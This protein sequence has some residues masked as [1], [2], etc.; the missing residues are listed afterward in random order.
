MANSIGLHPENIPQEL[1]DRRQWVVRKNETVRGRRTKVPYQ[2]DGT[3]ALVND[4]TTW[5]IFA[6]ALACYQTGE[7]DGTGYVFAADDPYCGID[8]DGCRNPATGDLDSF[9][10][11][12]TERFPTYT[13]ISPSGTGVKLI[14]KGKLP[15]DPQR[16][17]A[18]TRDSAIPGDG[19]GEKRPGIEAYQERRWFAMTGIPLTGAP[20]DVREVDQT[21]L[22]DW[23]HQTFDR[24]ASAPKVNGQ[25]S[26]D[27]NALIG[28]ARQYL[29]TM[30]PAISGQRG[31]DTT[32]RVA[33]VL[34]CRFGLTEDEA[35]VAVAEWNARCE[36]P[37][38]EA[39]LRHKLQDAAQEP[40]TLD[41]VATNFDRQDD[42]FN[43]ESS[44]LIPFSTIPPREVTWLWKNRIPCGRISVLGG[45]QGLGKS[46]LTIDFAGRIS[47]GTAWPDGSPCESG[48]V[49]FISGEDD[50]RDTIRP[51]LDA[52]GADLSRIWTFSTERRLGTK[53]KR[54]QTVFTLADVELLERAL[55]QTPD[56][57]LIVIDPIGAYVG[58]KVNTSADNEVRAVLGPIA[59]LAEASGSAVL[60][61]AHHRKSFGNTADD[62]IMGS[63]AFTALA[64]SVWHVFPDPSDESRRMLVAGKN[65][66]APR[67]DGFAFA[68]SG[69]PVRVQWDSKP[70]TMSA[71]ECLRAQPRVGTGNPAGE[72]RS[73][74]LSEA[75]D[76]LEAV[77]AEG[78]RPASEIKKLAREDGIAARTLDR[79][80]TALKI[81]AQL[82][83]FKGR[84]VWS[85][86]DAD[87][88]RQETSE[89]ADTNTLAHSDEPGALCP[90]IDE[91]FPP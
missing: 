65:N 15:V 60:I 13:E 24:P 7:W 29:A 12:I 4:S 85:L 17:G 8:A 3:K 30:P 6:D 51:R 18:K 47:S 73:S 26:G 37:W 9:A 66:L 46:Y 41:L 22:D 35:L 56:C 86:P 87:R 21:D 78:P 39:E 75:V 55:S 72:S 5:T 59:Q 57:K 43:E 84:W 67:Q 81:V 74:A 63:R 10:R 71:D 28:R 90:W 23:F 82:E 48:S 62:M 33:C 89:C 77:L 45:P 14:L 19:Y 91:A 69:Q 76:W 1:K 32:F 79:A 2:T 83:G 38:S 54:N 11:N 40:I 52:H 31:H 50:P 27:R 68:I 25:P 61:V 64:R 49:I 58:G 42:V 44:I 88:E 53:S 20:L 36:P 16:T 70:V 34:V 80:K